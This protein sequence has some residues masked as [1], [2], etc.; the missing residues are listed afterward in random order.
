MLFIACL[1]L[2]ESVHVLQVGVNGVELHLLLLL[3]VV[4]A[5]AAAVVVVVVAV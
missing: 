1:Q 2:S 3:V 4:A 5:A